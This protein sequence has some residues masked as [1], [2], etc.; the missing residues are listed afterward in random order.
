MNKKLY[1]SK[2]DSKIAGVCSGIGEY[3]EID[4]VVVRLIFI[5]TFFI[6]AGPLVY[7]IGWLIIPMGEE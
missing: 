4:P 1:K 2:N 5:A 3:F 6:G 7:L